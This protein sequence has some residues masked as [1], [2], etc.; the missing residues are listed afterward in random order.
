MDDQ[1]E[2]APRPNDL[3]LDP[4]YRGFVPIPNT[5]VL[6]KFNAKRRVDFTEDPQ[7]TGN[8][9]RFVTAQIPVD[10]DFF[11]GEGK[12]FNVNAKGSQLSLDVRAP[13]LPGSPRFY[14]HNDFFGSGGADLNF[15]VR[16]LYGQIFN[17]VLGQ[18][19]SVFEDPDAWPDTV[20]YE[21]PNSAIFA[22]RPLVRYQWQVAKKWQLNFGLEKPSSEVDTSIDP[23]AQQVN[24]LV[25]IWMQ[26]SRSVGSQGPRRIRLFQPK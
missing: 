18:S 15:R 26:L 9:D 22:R 19:F 12:Q 10:G 6:I 8:R 3:T 23:D 11:Q 1:Q 4:K 21:G 7:N 2:A 17:V 13:E 25:G 5:P 14:Y 16:Q 24:L 20:D